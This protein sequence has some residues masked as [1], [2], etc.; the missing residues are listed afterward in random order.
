MSTMN[1]DS[2]YSKWTNFHQLKIWE[3]TWKSLIFKKIFEL[4]KLS[5]LVVSLWECYYVDIILG[6]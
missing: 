5:I 2:M 4:F 3:S 6:K 1:I